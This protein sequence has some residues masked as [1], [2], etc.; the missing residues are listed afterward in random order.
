VELPE[1]SQDWLADTAG[2]VAGMTA[3]IDSVKDFIDANERAIGSVESL[4]T[5]MDGMAGASAADAAAMRNAAAATNDAADAAAKAAAADQL[6][7]D[8]AD[9]FIES[10]AMEDAALGRV[11]EAKDDSARAS[12]LLA[13][14]DKVLAGA[15]RE[16]A[17]DAAMAANTETAAMARASAAVTAAMAEES[18]ALKAAGAEQAKETAYQQASTDATLSHARAEELLAAIEAE[19]A[20]VASRM[21]TADGLAAEA[22]WMAAEAA[23]GWAEAEYELAAAETIAAA[24]ARD[25]AHATSI[26]ADVTAS[27]SERTV[28]AS[29]ALRGIISAMQGATTATRFFGLSWS[30]LHWI[31]GVSA[32]ILAV[33]VPA[34]IALGAGL[35]VAS[36]GA[37]NAYNHMTAL[38]TAAESMGG[39]FHTT[40]GEALGLRS[41]LQQAQDAANPGVY[42]LLGSGI[43]DV[44]ASFMGFGQVG[45]QVVHM[46]DEFSARITVDLKQMS[47]SGETQ[48]LLGNMLSDLQELGQVFGNL[49]HAILNFAADMPGLAEVLL[50]VVDA[51]SGVIL[52]VS[53]LPHWLIEGAMALEEFY[54][55]GGLAAS[56]IA[57]IGLLLPALAGAP[58]GIAVGLF[59][60]LAAIMGSVVGVGAQLVGGLGRV[61]GA[62]VGED[63]PVVG[64]LSGKLEGLSQEMSDAAANT[65]MM[66]TLGLLAAAAAGAGIAFDHYRNAAQRAID[67]VNQSLQSANDLQILNRTA[68]GIVSISDKM[69][70]QE[71]V[72]SR[73]GGATQLAT[74][75]NAQFTNQLRS[76]EGPLAGVGQGAQNLNDRINQLAGRAIAAIPGMSGL[77][78][79][80]MDMGGASQ[81]AAQGQELLNELQQKLL[82]TY[83]MVTSNLHT[84]SGAYHV[85]SGAAAQMA[86]EAGVNLSDGLIRLGAHANIA[87]QQI[88]NFVKGLGAMSAPAGVV[89]NDMEALG[90]QSQLA[91]TK[92][93]QLNQA[94]DAWMSSVTG[95]M[96]SF[97]QVQTAIQ[98]MAKDAAAKSASLAGSIGSVSR[99]AGGMTYTLKGMGAD[100]MQSWQQLTSALDQGNSAL[101]QLR[102]GMA[103]GVITG[104]QFKAT[105]QGLVG[106]MIPFV[107]HNR[108]AIEMLSNLGHEAGGP[109][110]TSLRQLEEWAGVKG[111]AAADKFSKGMNDASIAMGNMSK[112]AQNLSAVVSSDL[113]QALAA[114]ITQ[115]SGISGAVQTYA[116]DLSNSHT[117]ASVLHQDVVNI[118]KAM[119]RE[120]QMTAEASKGLNQA[121][122]AAQ[123]A[124]EKMHS[125][126]YY[127]DALAAAISNIPSTKTID[128]QVVSSQGLHGLAAAGAAGSIPGHAMGTM[129]AAPGIALVGEHGPELVM[130][131]GGEGVMTAGETQRLLGGIAPA[132]LSASRGGS[133]GGGVMTAPQAAELTSNIHVHLDGEEIW[134]GQQREVLKYN[135]RNG[136]SQSGSWAPSR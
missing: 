64:A 15:E 112:V 51:L 14:A 10:L 75:Q 97:S 134:R 35:L 2:Y 67:A 118:S 63:I 3:A 122:S 65:A 11:T 13:A 36:Q 126:A 117:P 107:A 53:T 127:A 81:S 42:E 23:R 29:G 4:K 34:I 24:A 55:W 41:T 109:V 101:D 129:D 50:K 25:H 99:A 60:R 95:S 37:T 62:I 44:K 83:H 82:P 91:G 69:A 27:E 71:Q 8:S 61:A 92:V 17:M 5:A 33:V 68:A 16:A 39:A 9:M 54:R 74:S 32:E 78:N 57:R 72:L 76:L 6:A 136:N 135:A 80:L 22:D 114:S 131:G 70:A 46:L 119:Q 59:G 49:G 106:E 45:L 12:L 28:S 84:L 52:W 89:G 87:G 121:G 94:W 85:S 40:M 115:F 125:A 77:G 18:A 58:L 30:A 116:K 104:G 113:D 19:E 38:W 48:G 56:I 132:L 98:G 21:A 86:Q 120:N 26:L 7:R 20:A 102:T 130:F 100:A 66:G 43:D 111:K 123:R 96:S 73:Y 124:A 47:A 90:I 79:A 110:T 1:V 88:E 128:V 93:S 103:E 105:V 108:T 31:F 133:G